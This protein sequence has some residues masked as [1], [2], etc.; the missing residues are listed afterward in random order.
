MNGS[1]STNP[2]QVSVQSNYQGAI[3]NQAMNAQNQN[4]NN[5]NLSVMSN[6][7]NKQYVQQVQQ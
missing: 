6:N 7:P 2:E 1:V 4:Q 5:A 3:L